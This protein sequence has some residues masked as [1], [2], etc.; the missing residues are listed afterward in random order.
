MS[1]GDE[2]FYAQL[3][4]YGVGDAFDRET[5]HFDLRNGRF[6]DRDVFLAHVPTKLR[7]IIKTCLEPDVAARFRSAIDVANALAEVDGGTLDWCYSTEGT[8]QV[9]KKNEEGTILNFA[10]MPDAST[11]CFKTAPGGKPRRFGDGCSPRMTDRQIRTFLD[12]H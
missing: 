1:N 6:P 5:F 8:K 9:W 11:E 7:T 3:A 2:S 12:K 4:K 10:V